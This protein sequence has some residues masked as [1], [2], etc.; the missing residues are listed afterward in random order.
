MGRSFFLIA[1]LP[2]AP[3]GL[4]AQRPAAADS[5]RRDTLEAVVVQAVRATL[6]AP[7]AQH[8]VTRGEI[9]RSFRGQDAPLYLTATP[10]MTSYSEAGGF[11][12]YSYLRLRGIDQTR[13]NISLDGVPLNDPEDQVLY[14]SNVPDFLRSV[15]SVQIQRGVGASGIGTAAYAGSLNFQSVPIAT[16]S[17][18][19]D[20]ELTAG[21]FGTGR[22]S[23]EYAT[24][25]LG[26]GWAG[27]ARV[28]A[29]HTDGYRRHSG[30]D[31]RSAF[32]S[33]GWFGDRDALKFTGFVGLSG[34]RLA[35]LA[36]PEGDL[37]SDRRENPLT[38][39]EGD[40]F[41]Q[42]MASLQWTH[43]IGGRSRLS[44]TAYRNSAAGAFDVLV[45][46]Q[47]LEIDNFF[48]GHTWYGVLSALSVREGDWSLDAGAHASDYHREH[49]MAVRPA[50]DVRAYSNVGYK[51]EQSAF[52][53][54]AYDV[55]PWRLSA[56]V[57]LRRASFRYQPS[58]NAG[59]AGASVDWSF[60]NPKAGLTWYP[61]QRSGPWTV[62]ASYGQNSREPARNDLFAGADDVNQSN[63][64]DV[65]PLSRVRPERV[66][67]LETGV[68]W[69]GEGLS[70]T[71]NAFDMEFRDEIAAIGALS[72]TGNPL[73]QNVDRSY[74]RGLEFDGA[75]R[76]NDRVTASGNLTVMKARI[77]VYQDQSTGN[78][79][80][81]VDPLLTPPTMANASVDIVLSRS[82]TF[83]VSARYVDRSYL[84]NDA[85]A[86]TTLAPAT[87]ADAALAWRFGTLQ[88]RLQV[89]NLLDANA[90]ASGYSAGGARYLYPVAARNFLFTT[91]IGL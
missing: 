46:P 79:Y 3:L 64:A 28:S 85:D 47:P 38:T 62:Y 44:L 77:A 15:E 86:S 42:E 55:G 76:V 67:D 39:A 60:V 31:S 40:R 74:R 48:L 1:F 17:R 23:A 2:L 43:A 14:F 19:G 80:L 59:V 83:L 24:G 54:A 20:L 21:S 70:A 36:A 41:H 56:D 88:L 65:L 63:A 71:V 58:A 30:N 16:T 37:T 11:S 66:R 25:I 84:A 32:S 8:N 34:T 90:Y 57:Q 78:R 27:Y 50:L 53:K 45:S 87:L 73:R 6:A 18:G 72:L 82:L 5:A 91:R 52:A 26:G 68:T 10:S 75:W 12:G 13:L 49:A 33:F 22:A 7:A 69:S 61:A 35:Y 29:Q 9:A 89:Y 81:D 4:R 51:Q